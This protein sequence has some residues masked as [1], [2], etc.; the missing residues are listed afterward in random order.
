[1]RMTS[2]RLRMRS[3]LVYGTEDTSHSDIWALPMRIGL[4]HRPGKPISDSQMDRCP[5]QIHIRVAMEKQIFALGTKER[6]EL[7][8]YDMKSATVPPL[9]L[10]DFGGRSNI[11]QRRAMELAIH[12][13]RTTLCGAAAVMEPNARS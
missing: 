9:P 5:I 1:M 2:C 4:F 10:R 12:P 3:D 13:I 8:R 7:V 11:F 6:G